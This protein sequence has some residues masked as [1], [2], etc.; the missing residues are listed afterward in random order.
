MSVAVTGVRLGVA[1]AGIKSGG[2][3][4]LLV[5]ALAPGTQ[6]AAV[7]TRNAF[8]AAPVV[9][10]EQHLSANQGQPTHL[11]INTGNANA[12]TGEPGLA[13]ANQC[14]DALAELTASAASAVLPFSTGVIGEPLP[15][16]QICAALPAALDA[17]QEDQWERA[18]S[19]I[20]TTDARPK[21]R[22]VDV[23]LGGQTCRVTGMAIA[24]ALNVGCGSACG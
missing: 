21:L 5:I 1:Q 7:F 2:K 19:A 12:G 20:L 3:D 18:A 6:T 11:I 17:L 15:A 23:E 10:A 14:C 4:D 8:R 24:P 13:A 9:V 16:D 22:G